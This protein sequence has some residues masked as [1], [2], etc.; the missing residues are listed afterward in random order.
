MRQ[1]AGAPGRTQASSVIP[2]V[3]SSEALS[4]TLT[5]SFAPSKDSAAAELAAGRSTS[6]PASV[7]VLPL[8]DWSAVVVPLPSSKP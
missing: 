5:Q 4:A 8:P 3:R 7:P 6:R 1:S 2:V